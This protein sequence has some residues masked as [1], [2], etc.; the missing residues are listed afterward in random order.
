MKKYIAKLN[1]IILAIL[2]LGIIGLVESSE[3]ANHY[4]R[5]GSSGGN[6]S[7]WT[8]AYSSLPSTL[9]RGDTYYI[10]DGSYGSYTFNDSTSGSSF[11]TI[12]K[13]IPSDH[14]T[15]T[16]WSDSYGDGVASFSKWTFSSDYYY[17]DG[18]VGGGPGNWE[19]GFGIEVKSTK[20]K[21]IVFN[22]GASHITI[23]HTEMT[24]TDSSANNVNFGSI[25]YAYGNVTDITFSYVYNHHV[26]G[27]NFQ[28][29]YLG[30][31]N[32]LIEY[33]KV[34]DNTGTSSNHSEIWSMNGSDNWT[35]RYNYIFAWRSTGAFYGTGPGA[36]GSGDIQMHENWYIYGN[37]FD[38]AGTTS[39][40]LIAANE[41]GSYDYHYARGWRV[42]NNT[43]IDI[44]SVSVGV[45]ACALDTRGVADN[46]FKNN[47]FYGNSDIMQVFGCTEDYN[48]Y[49]GSGQFFNGAH[50]SYLS[51]SPFV[52]YSGGDFSLAD[53]L[54]GQDLGPQWNIDMCG[55]VRGSDG[56]WDRGAIEYEPGGVG[57]CSGGKETMRPSPPSNLT[58]IQ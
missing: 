25:V 31:D 39:S 21:R 24:N 52:N 19:S 55:N 1:I 18:Q 48:S 50:D 43:F 45:Y 22:T 3:A 16:G 5:S 34:G 29:G 58:I 12:K 33:S 51:S 8:D 57:S 20:G 10:A 35:W 23:K 4:V 49:Q 13:A 54:A 40:W 30:A 6:G 9:I 38:Q 36:D 27:C 37:I 32:W 11:I 56:T 47:V 41:D 53:D 44:N 17:I 2:I 46:E 26:F 15:D 28:T 42:Y 14:G 7:S